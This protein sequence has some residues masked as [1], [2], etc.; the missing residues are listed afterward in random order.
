MN[1][2]SKDSL[3][4]ETLKEKIPILLE[5]SDAEGLSISLIRDAKIIW[6]GGFGFKNKVEKT[7]ITPETIFEV[8]SLSKPVV[9]YLALKAVEEGVLDLD[10][11]LT[12]YFSKPYL[13]N[14]PSLKQITARHVLTHTTGFPNWGEVRGSP[15]I[16]FTP[17]ERFSYSGEGFMYLQKTLETIYGKSLEVL[18]QEKLFR[19]M[20]LENVSFIWRNDIEKLS[21]T[22]Y[23]KDGTIRKWKPLEASAAGSLHMSA[24]NYAHFVLSL[25]DPKTDIKYQLSQKSLNDMFKPWIPVNDKG[26]SNN[27][28]I[29]LSGISESDVVFWGLGWGLEKVGEDFNIWHWGNNSSFHNLIFVNLK[30]K[31]G[32]V[33]MSNSEK[34]PLIWNELMEIIFEGE[35]PGFDWLMSFYW[36]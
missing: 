30:T 8:A 16:F 34:T 36:D 32:F 15:K 17:G 24:T 31:S 1:L 26:L 25:I 20:G 6:E 3:T 27:H 2:N 19:P 18:S 11:S 28:N 14:E 29:P 5:K 35:H 10:K 22:G 21:A 23:L 7:L 12:E 4:I 33:L 9:A 13:E